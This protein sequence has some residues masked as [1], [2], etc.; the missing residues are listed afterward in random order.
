M[1]YVKMKNFSLNLLTV[2]ACT[3]LFIS[4]SSNDTPDYT[5]TTTAN[6]A[7]GGA[8]MPSSGTFKKG[9]ALSLQAIPA[10]GW[11]FSKWEQDL[12]NTA[13]P[14]NITMTQD[15]NVVAKF[16]MVFECGGP[17]T[18]MYAGS[19]V[20]YGT[21]IGANGRCWLDRN[22][23]AIRVAQSLLDS[24]AYGDLY[25]W[26]RAADGH[27][28]RNSATTT[29]LSNRDQP[30][31]GNFI[32]AP[33]RPWDW[34]SPQK[35]NLWTGINGINNPCPRSYRL[36]TEAEWKTE[37]KSWSSNDREGAFASP[38]KLPVAG[39]TNHKTG[40]EGD[41]ISNYYRDNYSA[42]FYHSSSVN[43][44]NSS[45]LFFSRTGAIISVAPRASG[46]S[47]R[48]IKD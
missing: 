23:G 47:V 14:I 37:Y 42:G 7:K 24:L 17:V 32:L 3:L 25:Q 27:Q 28:K 46:S 38:L 45:Y 11:V 44:R 29:T 19:E 26:G 48:C 31:H 40:S 22:L 18:F 10:D 43:G 39:L 6:P 35:D 16:Q 15:Y 34:R 36:P 41:W 5:L 9:E 21:V 4:C 20:T 1:I 30:E 2:F 33:N 13:N 8:I 12:N